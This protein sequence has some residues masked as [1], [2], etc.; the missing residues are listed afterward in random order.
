MRKARSDA[1]LFV[2]GVCEGQ[3]LA[4]TG[5]VNARARGHPVRRSL[6]DLISDALEY[7]I[8]AFAGMTASDA[9]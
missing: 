3:G 1:R 5:V 8:P 4:P 2:F 6:R 7:W 9:D